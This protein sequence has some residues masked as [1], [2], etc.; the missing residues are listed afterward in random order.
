MKVNTPFDEYPWA[1]FSGRAMG[2]PSDERIRPDRDRCAAVSQADGK[3]QVSTGGGRQGTLLH[4]AGWKADG[5]TIT[6]AA[7]AAATPA[8]GVPALKGNRWKSA[9]AV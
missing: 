6:S 4:C 9:P 3:R 2:S 5:G 8:L 1:A 7:F